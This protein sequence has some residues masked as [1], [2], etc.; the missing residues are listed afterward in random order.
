[1]R[2]KRI[3]CH[4]IQ[5]KSL[6]ATE[7]ARIFDFD[8]PNRDPMNPTTTYIAVE[9]LSQMPRITRFCVLGG[10]RAADTRG[11]VGLT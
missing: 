9:P 5:T 11:R 8:H 3:T 2:L 10:E 1:V 4:F 6:T 7:T